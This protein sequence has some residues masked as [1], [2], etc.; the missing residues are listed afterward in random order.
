[1]EDTL[2]VYIYREGE[3]PIFHA[4]TSTHG[5]LY[6]SEGWFMKH[7]EANE[8]FVTKDRKDHLFYLPFSSR[9]I[10]GAKTICT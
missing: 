9:S 5:R 3:K 6:A 10:V 8:K 1:M 4:P 7:L 2:K